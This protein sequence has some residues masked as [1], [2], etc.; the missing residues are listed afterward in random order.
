MTILLIVCLALVAVRMAK[1][2]VET[3]YDL[4]PS[5]LLLALSI[6]ALIAFDKYEREGHIEGS[7]QAIQDTST[8][9]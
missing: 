9:H 6:L 2:F 1:W 4:A 8:D 3:A 5:I 7:A